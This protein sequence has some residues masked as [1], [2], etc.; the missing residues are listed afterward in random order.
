[1]NT[2][3]LTT[4]RLAIVVAATLLAVSACGDDDADPLTKEAFIAQA[5]AICGETQTAAEPYWAEFWAAYEAGDADGDGEEAWFPRFVELLDDVVPLDRRQIEDLRALEPPTT[6]GDLV[7]TMLDEYG[8][9]L[10]SMEEIAADAAAGDEAARARMS[11]GDAE[12]PL[13]EVARQAQAYGL[14]VC[15]A[16]Q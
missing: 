6:D 8:N 2:S 5:D 1:M 7:D 3:I 14:R 10:D 4:S 15:G 9:A 12:N 16:T 11:S 13:D